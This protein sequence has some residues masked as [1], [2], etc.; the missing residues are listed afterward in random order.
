MIE[1]GI[2]ER[3]YGILRQDTPNSPYEEV[4]EQI[5]RVGYAILDGGY[6]AAEIS[7]I[8]RAF[9]DARCAYIR[10]WG[11]PQLRLGDEFYTMRALLA[12]GGS[13][14]LDLAVNRHLL[15]VLRQLI[16]GKFILNQQ[17]GIINPPGGTYN[18]GAWHRD[19]PYQHFVSSAPLAINALFCVDDFNSENGATF[20]LPASH[21]TG[22]FPSEAYL[23]RNAVQVFARAGQFIVLDC[24]TF[25]SGGVNRSVRER[26]AVNHVFNIPYFKQQI[27]LP[28]IMTP[29]GLN[30]EVRQLLGFEGREA[31]SIADYLVS[32]ASRGRG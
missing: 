24:M 31:K 17:N 13:V 14:F 32:R 18:Q 15:E 10:R 6:D 27:S 19:L 11:E 8:S 28:E 29:E 25:H 26:R 1:R 21:K 16:I 30:A 12:H 5:R 20:V 4:A 9:D 23:R 7:T 22:N 2:P 3:R